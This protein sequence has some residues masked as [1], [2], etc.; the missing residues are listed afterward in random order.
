[1]RAALL[2]ILIVLTG[3][4]YAIPSPKFKPHIPSPKF[5]NRVPV[6]TFDLLPLITIKQIGHWEMRCN[7]TSCQK[8]WIDGPKPAAKKPP[9]QSKGRTVRRRWFR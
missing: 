7:G 1:M 2:L 6:P 4:A 9:A 5:K 3:S 8:V